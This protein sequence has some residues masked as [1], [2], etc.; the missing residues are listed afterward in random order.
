MGSLFRLLKYARR[1]RMKIVLATLYSTLN[2]LFDIAPEI[3]IGMAVDVVVKREE[4]FVAELG[5][6]TP[7]SQITVLAIATFFIWALESLFQYLH[8]IT[9][10]GLA[11]DLQDALRMDTY[12]QVQRLDLAWFEE[13]SVGNLLAILN[14]DVNQLERF[15]D[16]GAN[17]LI[18]LA[19]STLLIGAVF[20]YLDP[21][22][23]LLAILPVPVIFIGSS[24]FQKN[25]A[26]RYTRVREGRRPI[27]RGTGQQSQ[28]HDYHP[29]FHQGGCG[30]RARR[31]PEQGLSERQCRRDQDELGIHSRHSHGGAGRF[32][33]D[34]GTGW[35]EDLRG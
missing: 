8:S 15:L 19:V 6:H 10:R 2:K 9:W 25:L 7:Q 33:G 18:Q 4:S 30:K 23:A 20:F 3:L 26:P 17:D 24:F 13:N 1:W 16:T 21:T 34:P 27:G 32:H 28:R 11:Q 5:F 22:I 35:P 31:R 29:Q 14:D 12:D